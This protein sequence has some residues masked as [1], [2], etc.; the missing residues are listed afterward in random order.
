MNQNHFNR[1]DWQIFHKWLS[2]NVSILDCGCSDG[3]LLMR[4]QAD[5]PSAKIYGIEKNIDSVVACIARNIPVIQQDLEQGLGLFEDQSFDVVIL[6]QTL[7]TIHAT[8]FLLK[9]LV[10]VGKCAIV[11]FPNFAYWRHRWQ[12][13]QGRMPVSKALPFEW[14]NTPNVRVLTI[15]DFEHLAPPLG[16]EI[17]DCAATHHQSQKNITILKNWRASLG[18]YMI[19]AIAL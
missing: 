13:M 6:S 11:S 7:Q 14:Y 18:V 15:K 5:S 16:L 3:A 10:R 1:A 9:E 19:R 8:E 4:I 12:I 2:P 17:I